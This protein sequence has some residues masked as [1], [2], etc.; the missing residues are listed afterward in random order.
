[1][2]LSKKKPVSLFLKNAICFLGFF[3][4]FL[5]SIKREKQSAVFLFFNM[6]FLFFEENNLLLGFLDKTFYV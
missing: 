4:N 3:I 1:M 2:K 6:L 5:C